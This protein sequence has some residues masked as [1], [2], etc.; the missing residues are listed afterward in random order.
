MSLNESTVEAAAPE[1]LGDLGYAGSHG[2]HLAAGEPTAER[3]SFGA[4]VL[5]ER[6]RIAV[7]RINPSIPNEAREDAQRKVLRVATPSLVGTNRLFHAMLR[8]GVPAEYRRKDGSIAGDAVRLIDFSVADANDWFAVNQFTVIEGPITRRPDVVVFVNGL[9][10]G[11]LELKN[12]AEEDATT[13]DVLKDP[14]IF[15]E[16]I[17]SLF[18]YNAVV[19]ASDGRDARIG[20]I[21]ADWE[22]MMPW[23][24]I[25]GDSFQRV[26]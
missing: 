26:A 1:W 22:R 25:E 6:L 14:Q 17:P 23:R 21:S 3:D 8:D 4:V 2:P 16:Q 12:A 5:V 13:F 10:L 20:T 9:P 15:K 18:H 7:Q 11:V 19:V 24:T